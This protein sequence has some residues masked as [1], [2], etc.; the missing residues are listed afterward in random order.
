MFCK[1]YQSKNKYRFPSRSLRAAYLTNRPKTQNTVF[2]K[3]AQRPIKDLIHALKHSWESIWLAENYSMCKGFGHEIPKC[4]ITLCYSCFIYYSCSFWP[5]NPV[6]PV[7]PR[8][9]GSPSE[10][11][12]PAEL[13]PPREAGR[14]SCQFPAGLLRSLKTLIPDHSP[15]R[16]RGSAILSSA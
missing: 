16:L 8:Q 15:S 5:E 3:L 11:S 2:P 10:S 14:A 12:L 9:T 4:L 6:A 1:T 7:R 13:V